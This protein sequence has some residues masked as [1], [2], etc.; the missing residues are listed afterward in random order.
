MVFLGAFCQASP[1]F[2]QKLKINL[3]ILNINN[4]NLMAYD[5]NQKVFY[6][7]YFSTL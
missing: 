2:H 1:R 5:F 7:L 6:N 3:G 4:F